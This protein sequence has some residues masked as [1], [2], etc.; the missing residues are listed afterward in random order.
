MGLESGLALEMECSIHAFVFWGEEDF[1][2]EK[3]VLQKEPALTDLTA[4]H[5]FRVF[6]LSSQCFKTV[7][8][9]RSRC[10]NSIRS[11]MREYGST[12]T[13]MIFSIAVLSV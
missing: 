8:N 9:L 10:V 13:D 6:D 5:C 3:C 11:G 2:Y 1:S 4:V 7:A 12:F